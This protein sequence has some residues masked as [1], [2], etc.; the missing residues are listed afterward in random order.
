MDSSFSDFF[1]CPMLGR[2]RLLLPESF[3]PVQE[4]IQ[5]ELEL[6][7]IVATLTDDRLSLAGGRRG[8]RQYVGK[9][10]SQLAHHDRL[11]LRIDLSLIHI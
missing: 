9:R 7:L 4:Q 11:H 10:P 2:R 6:E 1:S 3:E 8:D 5:R